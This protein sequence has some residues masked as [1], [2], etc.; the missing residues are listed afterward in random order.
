MAGT[1]GGAPGGLPRPMLYDYLYCNGF[2]PRFQLNLLNFCGNF[3]FL[4]CEM[5]KENTPTR[6]IRA[7]V[8]QIVEKV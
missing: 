7:G 3:A 8:P 2:D 5:C 6:E 4:L 1:G